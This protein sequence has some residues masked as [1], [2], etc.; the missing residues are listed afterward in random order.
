VAAINTAA[1][2]QAFAHYCIPPFI[3]NVAAVVESSIR[4]QMSIHR[5]RL[6]NRQLADA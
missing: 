5:Y 3:G 6:S 4:F 1:E 2:D